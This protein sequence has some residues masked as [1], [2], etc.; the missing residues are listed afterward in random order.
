MKRRVLWLSPY[1]YGLVKG[2]KER[3]YHPAAWVTELAQEISESVELTICSWPKFDVAGIEEIDKEGI[4]F[5]FPSKPRLRYDLATLYL[6][7]ISRLTKYLKRHRDQFDLIHVHGTEHQYEIVARRLKLPTIISIQGLITGYRPYYPHKFTAVYLSWIISSL[8]ERSGV[9]S[10]KHFFCR[11]SW[12]QGFVMK[13][14]QTATIHENWELIRPAFFSDHFDANSSHLVF[15]GGS[16]YFK[17]IRETLRGLNELLP[18]YPDLILNICGGG[19]KEE[20]D[21][22]IANEGLELKEANIRFLGY[23]TESQLAERFAKSFCLI[24]PSYMDNS[25]NSICE[26]QVSGLPVIASDVGGVGSLIEDEASGLLVERYDHLGIVAAV[27]RL[28]QEPTLYHKIS[29]N[30]KA[31]ARNRHNRKTIVEKTLSAY[32]KVLE[33]I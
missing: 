27:R 3:K 33:G 18:E 4:H 19:R 10:C 30:S 21:Q 22:I 5:I 29:E 7:R 8:Y 16:S 1:P 2:Y 23:Q 11:T 32:E 28:K 6:S 17:G 12:D 31:I 24:H 15:L 20:V 9:R 13:W 25:P 26:A 14:N